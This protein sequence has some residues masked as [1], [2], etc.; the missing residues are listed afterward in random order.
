[1]HKEFYDSI[2]ASLFDG[3]LSEDQVRAMSAISQ[4][5]IDDGGPDNADAL[6]YAFATAYHEPGAAMRPIA[7]NLNYSSAARI[8]KVWPSRFKT[9]AAAKP[10]V[11]NP[12]KL[13]NKVYGDRDGLVND[14]PGDGWKYRG[15]GLAQITGKANYAKFS[16]LLDIDLVA[17]PDR[18]LE[19]VNAARILVLGMVH[20][21]FTGKKLSDYFSGATADP[22]NA[23][24]ILNGDV[25]ANGK[26]VAGYWLK[27]RDAILAQPEARPGPEAAP[28]APESTLGPEPPLE[29][30][31]P[32]SGGF[33]ISWLKVGLIGAVI[34]ALLAIFVF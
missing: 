19:V 13:A 22:V 34:V 4:A 15:R 14:Q 24:A 16:K 28:V 27:F 29:A 12:E 7:E 5:W 31:A 9:E 1:M 17:D 2:R 11:R 33:R 21:L 20:G 18:A 26:K 25:A 10:Y 30:P 32:E 3:S 6:A 23:R 8:R